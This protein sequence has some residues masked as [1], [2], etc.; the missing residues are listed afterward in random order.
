[1]SAV[2]GV[3]LLRANLLLLIVAAVLIGGWLFLRTA[4]TP[5]DSV[6]QF[7]ARVGRGEPLV[8]EFFGNT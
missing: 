7:D 2:T 6:A 5:F 1:M 3:K 4:A 8:L